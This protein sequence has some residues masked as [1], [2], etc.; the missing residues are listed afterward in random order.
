[1][2]DVVLIEVDSAERRHVAAYVRTS[3]VTSSIRDANAPRGTR[4][5]SYTTVGEITSYQTAGVSGTRGLG[6]HE[7]GVPQLLVRVVPFRGPPEYACCWL[8][9]SKP[10]RRG[11][12]P[13]R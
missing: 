9:G 11:P 12:P 3:S 13:A 6:P 5:G 7:A 4:R 1:M 10:H 2:A 8:P